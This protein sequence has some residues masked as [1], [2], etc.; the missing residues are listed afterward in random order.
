[1]AT[2]SPIRRHMARLDESA[3][4][5]LVESFVDHYR[6]ERGGLA[7]A[8]P[9]MDRL[10]RDLRARGIRVGVVTSKL[11]EDTLAELE[12]TELD[13][14]VD[15]V[16]AFEDTDEHK[17][18]AAP[19]L[20]ALRL[21]GAS[22]GAGVGDLPSDVVSARRAGLRTLAV[23]WGYGNAPELQKAGAE[24]VCETTGELS[25]AL[26]ERLLDA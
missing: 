7:R 12:E 8:F 1:M 24:R 23:A 6:R 21:L 19:H 9:G 11:R 25:E 18:A 22:G 16:I 5:A 14:S 2:G 17:P 15:V 20:E 10:L 3:A 4:D 26:R 13:E